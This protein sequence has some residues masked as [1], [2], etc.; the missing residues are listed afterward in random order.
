MYYKNV[1]KKCNNILGRRGK[2][3]LKYLSKK[4]KR[5]R[6]KESDQKKTPECVLQ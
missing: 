5:I 2:F 6:R 1:I 3:I 4:A